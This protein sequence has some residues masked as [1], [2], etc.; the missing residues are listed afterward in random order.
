MEQKDLIEDLIQDWSN[1]SPELDTSGMEV[2]GRILYLGRILEKRASKS[3]EAF[4]IHYTDFD[5]LAT[6]RRSGKPFELTPSVL[7]KSVVITSGAMTAALNRLLKME[8][9][10]RA[11]D[12]E[13]GRVKRVGL[14]DKGMELINKTIHLRFDEAKQAV[15]FLSKH[16]QQTL[17]NELKKMI[18][19]LKEQG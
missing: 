4:G 3:V 13:D 5:V 8:L 18:L 10:Y 15:D 19:G 6:L 14:T 17:S 12:P 2:V 7:M 1:E 16:E 11:P 9:V